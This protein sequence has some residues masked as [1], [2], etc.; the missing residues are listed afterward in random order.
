M[1][2]L[3]SVFGT[4]SRF[5]LVFVSFN[6]V[7]GVGFHFL[8]VSLDTSLVF[9]VLDDAIFLDENI[10]AGRTTLFAGGKCS[11]EESES[12]VSGFDKNLDRVFLDFLFVVFLS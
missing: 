9:T 4:S 11:F 3:G 2:Y 6:R 7:G 5:F 12:K 10:A 1:R 8:V